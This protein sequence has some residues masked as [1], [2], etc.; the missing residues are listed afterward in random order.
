LSK[1]G[2][3]AAV[4]SAFAANGV[5]IGVWAARIPDIK[6]HAGIDTAQLGLALTSMG[7]GAILA[8]TLSG[9]L[10]AKYGSHTMTW[11]MLLLCTA[12]LPVI[13]SA[14]SFA[15]LLP[16][17]FVFGATQGSMDVC[18]NANG[19][20]VERAGGRPIMSR[21]HACWSIGYFAGA[22]WTAASQTLTL[23]VFSQFTITAAIL[24]LASLALARTML[25]DRQASSGPAFR[26][27][28]R[29]LLLL[30][31]MAL[32]SMVAEGSSM[33]WSAI[34]VRDGLGGTAFM[35][36]MVVAVYSATQIVARVFGDRLT[37][38]IGPAALVSGGALL[39]ALGLGLALGVGQPVAA[40]LGYGLVGM[41]LAAIVPIV[42]RAGGSQPGIASGVGIAAV[43]T[44]SYSGGLMG[45]P[46]IGGVA[47]I[48]GL[49]VALLIPLGMLLLVAAMAPRLLRSPAMP[50]D[51]ETEA[52]MLAALPMEP[53]IA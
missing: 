5:M 28:P 30:G 2:P 17:L 14:N 25:A 3:A 20:A 34:L 47:N 1:V 10:A 22:V 50:A 51:E 45:P 9:R 8:M 24:A 4:A 31:L 19:L 29:V 41:G 42:F 43:S 26:L 44:M 38:L 27:P 18:M 15:T 52:A 39:A 37:E 46:V 35:G 16:V 12:F 21:L 33:D 11:L 40:I 53:P 6:A 13:A 48:T 23:T 36:A 49:R 32:C 7:I